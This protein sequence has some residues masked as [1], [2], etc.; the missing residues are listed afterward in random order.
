MSRGIIY[1]GVGEGRE[2]GLV[3][4]VLLLGRRRAVWCCVVEDGSLSS[5]FTRKPLSQTRARAH[6]H[7]HTHTH[8]LALSKTNTTNFI[9]NKRND[10]FYSK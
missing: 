9:V 7:T 3:R 10:G 1:G 4:F 6:T 8:T 5:R 2:E